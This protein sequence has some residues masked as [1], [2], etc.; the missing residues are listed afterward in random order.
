MD[1]LYIHNE[2][3][4]LSITNNYLKFDYETDIM[5]GNYNKLFEFLNL[6]PIEPLWINAKKVS[7]SPESFIKNYKEIFNYTENLKNRYNND[8]ISR[9]LKIR[10]RF[11]TFREI[12]KRLMKIA[13]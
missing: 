4:K 1:C 7:P 2:L 5:Q 13:G 8:E 9:E 11:D 10:H 6:K 3:Q 12:I